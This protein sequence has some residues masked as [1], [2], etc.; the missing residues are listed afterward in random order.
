MTPPSADRLWQVPTLERRE[1]MIAG[2]SGGIAAELG[3]GVIWVR[4]GFIAL[5]AA[6][7]WGALLY[8]VVWGWM[9]VE[10][11]RRP[12]VI[13]HRV[14]KARNQRERIA[15][16]AV[17]TFG[18]FLLL[19]QLI[20]LPN[21]LVWPL[22]LLGAGI[23]VLLQRVSR[24]SSASLGRPLLIAQTVGGLV[25]V[26]VAIVLLI[27]PLS[28]WSQ[29]SAGMAI[30]VGIG[31][32]FLA[33]LA[34]WWWRL[35]ADLDAERTAR[36]R[37]EERA[38][39]AAHIHDSVLQT[40][41]LIQRHG[42]DPQKM[43]GLARRQERELRNWLDPGRIDRTGA[44]VRGQLDE[45]ISDLEDLHGIAV[46]TVVVG[47]CLVDP[48]IEAMLGAAREAIV[49]AAKHARVDQIDVY[50]EIQPDEIQ[51]FIRDSGLGFDPSIIAEDRQG[52]RH[53]IQQRMQRAGGSATITSAPGHGTEVE[54]ALP[55]RHRSEQEPT[56][57]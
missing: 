2:V 28:D 50:I 26:G 13:V 29:A 39:V 20:G 41:S 44:G 55:R 52:I 9:S 33:L 4:L 17:A 8:A 3:L 22:G 40:L 15:G 32:G 19:D 36:V 30:G 45:M 1:R 34:P 31:L 37:S 38:D 42:D 10:E 11:Y 5:F 14:P 48:A 53:S 46:D 57:P 49:N 27:R 56:T 24:T 51:A 25:L 16:S 35:L 23:I 47:D 54:L 12:N 6:G 18:I 21:A 7:G 43:V